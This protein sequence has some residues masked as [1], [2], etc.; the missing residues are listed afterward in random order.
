VLKA[1]I[2]VVHVADELGEVST[3][4]HCVGVVVSDNALLQPVGMRSQHL[5]EPVSALV[6]PC[7]LAGRRAATIPEQRPVIDIVLVRVSPVRRFIAEVID[8]GNV[9]QC[10]WIIMARLLEVVEVI[11]ADTLTDPGLNATFTSLAPTPSILEPIVVATTCLIALLL[12]GLRPV[13][14]KPCIVNFICT[15]CGA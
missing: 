13:K 3:A 8:T 2:L 4:N 10:A 6:A 1:L 5:A 9:E 12:C 14:S 7:F 11:V 15:T